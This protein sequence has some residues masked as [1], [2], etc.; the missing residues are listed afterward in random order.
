MAILPRFWLNAAA[1][2]VLFLGSSAL[3]QTPE[4]LA[5]VRV[6]PLDPSRGFVVDGPDNEMRPFVPWGFNYLGLHGFLAEDDWH[7][8]EGWSRIERDFRQM[9]ALGA[10]VVRW[11]LQLPTYITG[12]DTVDAD[13]LARLKKLLALAHNTGLYLDLTGL[14]A[15]RRD[16]SP[17]WYD[18]LDEPQRWDVQARFWEAVAGACQGNPAV[19]CYDL[20]NEPVIGAPTAADHPWLGGELGGF[21]FVQRIS[22][23]GPGRESADIAASWIDRMVT[24][25][26]RHD[27]DTPVTVGII[28]WA[29]VWP[30]ATSD[31]FYARGKGQ[32]LDRLDFVSIHVYPHSGKLDAER[33]ATAVYDLGKPLVVEEIFPMGCT[34]RELNAYVHATTD[35]VDGWVAHYFGSTPAEHRRGVDPAGTQTADF[36]DAWQRLGTHLIE[37]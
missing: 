15:F 31:P 17:T 33:A 36:L 10:N 25:I 12:P 20:M 13:Q 35:R 3:S 29:F 28:P 37:P 7:T 30:T 24:A 19:F 1:L 14:N 34:V 9:K 2:L 6:N 5:R 11:H 8:P 22:H 16:R 4:P 23:G 32:G 21:C 26:R 18:A 27:R